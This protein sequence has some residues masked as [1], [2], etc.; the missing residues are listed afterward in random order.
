MMTKA[1]DKLLAAKKDLIPLYEL[2]PNTQFILCGEQYML[3]R[4]DG[5]YSRCFDE[6]GNLLH[7][8]AFTDVEP[9]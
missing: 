3:E 9:C 7:I 6:N 5:M 2:K 1:E 4:I 8:A